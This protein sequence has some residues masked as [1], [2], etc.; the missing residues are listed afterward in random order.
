MPNGRLELKPVYF[1]LNV[2]L[3][4][5]PESLS[6]IDESLQTTRKY[7]RNQAFVLEARLRVSTEA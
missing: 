6:L 4:L 3:E 2:R 1:M 5:K 7:I